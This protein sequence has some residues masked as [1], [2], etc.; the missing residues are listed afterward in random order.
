MRTTLDIEG[1]VLAAVKDLARREG[2]T[3]GEILS[4]LAR[5]ALTSHDPGGDAARD[6]PAHGFRPFPAGP[7]LVTNDVIAD[8]RDRDGI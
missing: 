1:D 2:R 4:M 6:L 7:T 8:L 5:R 3:A